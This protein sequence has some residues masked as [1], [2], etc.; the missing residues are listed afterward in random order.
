MVSN[1]DFHLKG[2]GKK[3]Y[4]NWLFKEVSFEAKENEKILVQGGNGT[5]KSTLLR[6]IAG[7]LRPNYGQTIFKIDGRLI[8]LSQRYQHISWSGPNISLFPDLSCSK[9]L[10]LH[11]KF[12]QNLLGNEEAILH[13]LNLQEHAHKSLRDFSSGMLQRFMVGLALFSHTRMI[14]LDEPTSNMDN[15]NAKFILNLIETY[16]EY[17]IL[18]IASN[19]TRDFLGESPG[20]VLDNSFSND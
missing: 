10:A 14:L 5:G 9:Q 16:R 13:K 3:F 4:Q 15:E 18:V 12:A 20:I 19:L 11:F 6:I 8:P 2:V 1:I 17:R 7:Q